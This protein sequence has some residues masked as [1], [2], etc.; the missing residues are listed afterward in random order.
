MIKKSY[1]RFHPII[2]VTILVMLGLVLIFLFSIELLSLGGITGLF[3]WLFV[4]SI[5]YETLPLF[6][7]E[8]GPSSLERFTSKS[9]N[10]KA[11]T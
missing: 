1:Y 3:L 2:Y 9:S 4:G 6:W 7:D 8:F 10:P 11:E 5:A